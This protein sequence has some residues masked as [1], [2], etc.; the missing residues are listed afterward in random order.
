[1]KI[2]VFGTGYVGLVT[3]ASLAQLGHDVLCVDVDETKIR[4]LKEGKIPFFEPGLLELVEVNCSLKKLSFTS[5]V[6]RGVAFAEVIF[7]CVGTPQ[8]KDGSANLTFVFS[9]AETVAKYSFNRKVLINKSTVPP[10]TAK[11]CAQLIEEVKAVNGSEIDIVSNPE[12][13]KQGS[14]VYD[15]N[16]PDKIVIGAVSRETFDLVRKIY[17][18]LID[19][20]LIVETNWETAEMI[21]YANNAFLATKISFVNEIANICDLIGA[22]IKMITKAMGMDLRIGPYF[23]NAGVGYGGS[24]FPKDVLA[25]HNTAGE[26]GYE[27]VLLREVD[28]FNE[29]Q[30]AIFIPKILSELQRVKGHKV[31]LWGLS[32]KPKTSDIRGATSLV[33]IDSLL[34]KGVEICV[35]DPEAIDEVQRIYGDKIKYAC[36]LEESA[37]GSSIIVLVT[38]WDEFRNVDFGHIGEKMKDKILFDGRN[39]YE[40]T[41]LRK[42]GFVYFGVGRQ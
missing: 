42:E 24:C 19:E 27:S 37:S 40:P 29:R 10:G 18:G 25:L 32:F 26:R 12:F 33:L 15:F 5:D 38:E 21:K 1:M 28:A 7:N 39:V 36:S 30:K 6:K 2:S 34:A 17:F 23:L 41:Q 31:A 13:L 16:H 35:Y 8:Q 14:A 20:H 4:L 22:D 11:K 9:V 3:G